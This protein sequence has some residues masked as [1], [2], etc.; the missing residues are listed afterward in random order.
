M[1]LVLTPVAAAL[2]LLAMALVPTTAHA[3]ERDPVLFV[4]GYSGD[5]GN[6]DSMIS[7]FIADGWQAQDLHPITYDY[8]A[9]NVETAEL[10]ADEVDAVLADPAHDKVDIVAHSMGSLSSRWYVKFLGGQDHVDNWISLAGP[11]EGSIV[12]LPCVQTEPSCQEVVVGSSFLSQLNSG[13][14]TPGDVTYTTF[15]SLCDF[16][17]RPSSNVTL[18]G[19]DN[20]YAGCVGHISFLNDDGVSAEV[21]DILS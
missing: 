12:E 11:N 9:S 15:R 6:W 2:T 18:S 3:Q 14:P 10:I 1:R 7:D 20:R 13:D 19:A 16:I 5:A 17:V 4:H 8:N 21:R